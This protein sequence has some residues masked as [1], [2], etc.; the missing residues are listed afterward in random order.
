MALVEII[1]IGDEL[2]IGQ[3]VDTNSAWM[4]VELNKIGLRV[5]QITSVSDNKPAIVEALNSAKT[6]AQVILITGGLG[7]TKDDVTKTTLAEYFNTKLVRSQEVYNHLITLFKA[8]GREL[9]DLN[10]KQADVPE[11]AT[12]LMNKVGTAPGMMIQDQ[13]TI[14]VS[15]PGVPYEMKYL[16]EHEVLPRMKK[17]F[18]Q[19][20]I[21]H[22]V[23]QTQGIG[24][25]FLSEIIASWEDSLPSHIKLAYLP[26]VGQ[27][28]LRLTAIGSDESALNKELDQLSAKLYDLA[29][30]HIYAEGE[31]SLV[32][33]IHELFLNKKLSLATAE[34]CTG[35]SIAA[36]ITLKA[37]ASAFFKGS[38]IAY[39]NAIK[40]NVLGV[41]K[42]ILISHGAV[43]EACVIAMAEGARKLMNTDW[44][45]S[46]SGIAGPTGGSKEKPIGT[47]WIGIAGPKG[48]LARQ[49]QLG[50]NR[51]RFVAMAGLTTLNLLRKAVLKGLQ[52]IELP[53]GS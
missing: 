45:I 12:V 25:S 52:S 15:M 20:A 8:R 49:F 1:T 40:E 21:V 36:N 2:L 42:S 13:G 51:E 28:R 4:G 53:K 37:G 10:A 5:I 41:D 27:V 46:T 43:S 11:I 3:V 38:I 17:Q 7:P 39:D 23:F 47:I 18:T 19:E 31:K 33:V 24:E 29:A 26:A 50:E 9:S 6:R 22:R 14:I 32:D 44:A 48:A 35:G 16:M 34:S 30:E